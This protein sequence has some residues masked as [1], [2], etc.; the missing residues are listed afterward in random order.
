[1][2]LKLIFPILHKTASGTLIG[3]IR[4]Y[5]GYT[6]VNRSETF[7]KF[8]LSHEYFRILTTD[9]FSSSLRPVLNIPDN[10]KIKRDLPVR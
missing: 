6:D 3:D 2:P 9:T 4:R 7:I 1:M 5:H 8:H 10:Y